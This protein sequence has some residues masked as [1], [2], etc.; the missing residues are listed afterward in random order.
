MKRDRVHFGEICESCQVKINN[1]SFDLE[2]YILEETIVEQETEV[3]PVFDHESQSTKQA[4]PE[5]HEMEPHDDAGPS[6][7]QTP[8]EYYST[9]PDPDGIFG[10]DANMDDDVEIVE[11]KPEVLVLSDSSD[12]DEND[13]DVEDDDEI[14]EVTLQ[15]GKQQCTICRRWVWRLKEHMNMH[16][17]RKVYGCS[18]KNCNKKAYSQWQIKQHMVS[19]WAN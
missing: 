2:S 1:Q 5:P 16:T 10:D 17:K 3:I 13:T 18:H 19:R 14:D 9:E 7:S 15:Q 8:Q 11:S 4:E 6:D 12:F